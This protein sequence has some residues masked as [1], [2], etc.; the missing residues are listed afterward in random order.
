MNMPK[1][2]SE[3]E[4]SWANAQVSKF[5]NLKKFEPIFASDT[6]AKRKWRKRGPFTKILHI[7]ERHALSS[8][9]KNLQ[10]TINSELS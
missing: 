1:I 4:K 10:I 8:M 7:H 2:S 3:D 9:L 6:R 5:D